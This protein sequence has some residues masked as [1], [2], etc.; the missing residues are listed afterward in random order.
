MVYCLLQKK[1]ALVSRFGV[2][3]VWIDGSDRVGYYADVGESDWLPVPGLKHSEG[4]SEGWKQ[5]GTV[6]QV[7]RS[8]WL[9]VC[10]KLRVRPEQGPRVRLPAPE[11]VHEVV[12]PAELAVLPAAPFV[13]GPRQRGVEHET[14]AICSD[15]NRH[16]GIHTGRK[17]FN[18]HALKW[19]ELSPG[20]VQA[21]TLPPSLAAEAPG[22]C[23]LKELPLLGGRK[24]VLSTII[25]WTQE[26]SAVAMLCSSGCLESTSFIR[27]LTRVWKT[28]T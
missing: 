2:H 19:N 25:L 28:K 26:V 15:C 20:F 3:I 16:V 12:E 13:V 14:Y 27:A 24:D 23:R 6:C 22:G 17:S 1:P 7:V 21:P 18:F 9:L 10:P 4:L 11:L 5:W 8:F